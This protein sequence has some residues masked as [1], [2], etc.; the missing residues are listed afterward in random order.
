MCVRLGFYSTVTEIPDGIDNDCDGFVD[1]EQCDG[2]DNDG[3]GLSDE[4]VGSCLLRLKTYPMGWIGDL[5]EYES[6]VQDAFTQFLV[7]SG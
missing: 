3:D 6:F 2:F 4:D 7:Q 5:N 1:D